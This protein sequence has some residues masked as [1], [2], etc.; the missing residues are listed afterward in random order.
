MDTNDCDMTASDLQAGKT[1]VA[2]GQKIT[3]TGKAFSFA[4]Y[5]DCESNIMLPIPTSEINT[6]IVSAN[7]YA[8]KMIQAM[9]DFR[10]VN[11]STAQEVA[12]INIDGE[13]YIITLQIV[14]N[15]LTIACGKN[16]T[17]QVMFGKDDYI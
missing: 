12:T 7:G 16:V 2:R 17:L 14:S 1:G 10:E 6:I 11:F 13:D 15:M 9:K 4:M 8:V 5:G 3:G